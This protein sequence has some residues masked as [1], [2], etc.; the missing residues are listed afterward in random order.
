MP[1]CTVTF[2]AE[3]SR[4]LFPNMPLSAFRALPL[5]PLWWR[6]S[7][8]LSSDLYPATLPTGFARHWGKSASV[9]AALCWVARQWLCVSGP[10]PIK[11]AAR[12]HSECH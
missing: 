12:S 10:K 9:A 2:I 7:W 4:R 1:T 6:L 3:G 8:T 11:P 5:C